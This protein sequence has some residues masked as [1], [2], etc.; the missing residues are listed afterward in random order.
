MLRVWSDRIP[1]PGLCL[2]VYEWNLHIGSLRN[3]QSLTIDTGF[4]RSF[5]ESPLIGVQR[6]DRIFSNPC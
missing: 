1:S 3:V 4:D 2:D 6:T 5:S